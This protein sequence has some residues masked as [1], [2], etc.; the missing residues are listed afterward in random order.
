MVI[1]IVLVAALL[2]TVLYAVRNRRH[3]PLA[4]MGALLFGMVGVFC[5]IMPQATTAAANLLGV[6]RGTDLLLYCFIISSV[7]VVLNLHL[8]VL[9]LQEMVTDMARRQALLRAPPP[10][11]QAPASTGNL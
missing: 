9:K 2:V 5:V 6:G 1:R 7:L 4:S 10:E 8:R 3:S 11:D